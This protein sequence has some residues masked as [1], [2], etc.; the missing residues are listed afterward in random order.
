VGIAGSV[1]SL[2]ASGAFL[3]YTRG[4]ESEAD[5]GGFDLAVA[6]GYDPRQAAVIWTHIEEDQKSNPNRR[7]TPIFA[8]NHPSNAA[9]LSAMTKRANQLAAQSHA[10]NL[11]AESYRAVI[12]P[13]RAGWLEEELNRNATDESLSLINRLL[14]VEPSS[15]ELQYFL[16]EA[17]R[18]RNGK[19]DLDKA[20]AAY[21]AAIA[22]S[23]AP[24]TVH[25]GLGLVALKAGKRD[26][27]RESFQKYLSLSADAD[28]RATIQYYLTNIGG[29]Q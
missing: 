9:R 3:S 2:V 15:G 11:G 29:S 16:G 21:Q 28:D 5:D 25:R 12:G 27:A 20:L 18:R 26:I 8:S 10:G 4:Q 19:G 7:Q 22:N 13:H 6:R 17:Y 24:V 23:G 1:A 14:K